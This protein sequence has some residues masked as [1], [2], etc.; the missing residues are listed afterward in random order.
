MSRQRSEAMEAIRMGARTS[1]A[2][3][4]AL[5]IT[6]RH[7]SVLLYNLRQ[8]GRIRAIGEIAT[9]TRGQGY[10]AYEAA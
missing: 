2:L 6:R 4:G 8:E 10:R 1:R 3:A 5:A 9:P 7:A